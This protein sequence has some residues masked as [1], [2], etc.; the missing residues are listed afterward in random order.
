MDSCPPSP[1]LEDT[2]G[3][4]TDAGTL[5]T[6]SHFYQFFSYRSEFLGFRRLRMKLMIIEWPFCIPLTY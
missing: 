2:L 3:D 4:T 5:F 1:V 6:P